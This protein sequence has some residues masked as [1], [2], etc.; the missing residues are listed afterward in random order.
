VGIRCIEAVGIN[1]SNANE[2]FTQFQ[3]ILETLSPTHGNIQSN[4]RIIGLLG[5]GSGFHP[6]FSARENVYM[7]R[8]VLGSS[9]NSIDQRVD[10]IVDFDCRSGIGL[11]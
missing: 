10:S 8:T 6:D 7:N 1:G 2:K 3:M 9:R 11:R 5:I 4:D